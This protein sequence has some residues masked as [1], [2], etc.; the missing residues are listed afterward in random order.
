MSRFHPKIDNQVPSDVYGKRLERM[1]PVRLQV[2]AD[3]AVAQNL[4][5]VLT[6]TAL[7]AAT[8]DITAGITSPAFPRSLRITGNASGI[9]GNVVIEGTNYAGEVISETIAL[10]GSTAVEGNK[11]FRTVTKINLP[12]RTNASGD[13]VSVGWGNKLGLPYRLPHNTVQMAFRNNAKEGTAPTV[14]TSETALESNTVLLNS[15]L[16]GTAVDVYLFV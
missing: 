14:T 11:A 3:K 2:S 4:T 13:T 15:A 16:N 8:Q 9:A 6:A 5:G 7:T 1:Y 12:A 10:N